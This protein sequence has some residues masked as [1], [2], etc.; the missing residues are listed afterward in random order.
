MKG[1]I[2]KIIK[3]ILVVNNNQSIGIAAEKIILL[4]EENRLYCKLYEKKCIGVFCSVTPCVE[5]C[6][7]R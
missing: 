7:Y 3:S 4:L 1:Q 6:Q 5:K 2:E